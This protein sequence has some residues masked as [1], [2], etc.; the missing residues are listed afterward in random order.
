MSAKVSKSLRSSW[1]AWAVS[2]LP[3]PHDAKQVIQALQLAAP[4]APSLVCITSAQARDLGLKMKAAW[5][6]AMA[7]PDFVIGA[8]AKH[9]TPILAPS[10]V[11]SCTTSQH[12]HL[13]LKISAHY[14]KFL[15]YIQKPICCLSELLCLRYI[16]LARTLN[17]QAGMS[18]IRAA[19]AV[20]CF[21]SVL[22]TVIL[23]SI[24]FSTLDTN[25]VRAQLMQHK[26]ERSCSA[27][28]EQG[29]RGAL[30]PPC[31]ATVVTLRLPGWTGI[32]GMEQAC[33]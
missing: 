14:N 17:A 18:W 8:P 13:S 15:L 20:I 32:L 6:H 11:P 22:L 12:C 2:L 30:P 26:P 9:K 29:H 4:Q 1:Q 5:G 19:G 23:V 3:R 21:V 10:S 16:S 25:E 33:G 31:A 7:G 27:L 28:L 24:S